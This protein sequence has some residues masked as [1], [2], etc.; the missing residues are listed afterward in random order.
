MWSN[1]GAVKETTYRSSGPM[2]VVR[3]GKLHHSTAPWM[4]MMPTQLCEL[5]GHDRATSGWVWCE[6]CQYDHCGQ[7]GRCCSE[8]V[9]SEES[10]QSCELAGLLD[11]PSAAA[12]PEDDGMQHFEPV[13]R[14]QGRVHFFPRNRRHGRKTGRCTSQ[15]LGH[16]P[17]SFFLLRQNATRLEE[18]RK[19]VFVI[20]P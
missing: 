1:D 4:P 10:S 11:D 14:L 3:M 17:T 5:C 6:K 15:H 9:E 13:T 16:G 20:S 2:Q 7:C 12:A 8:D 18:V 19:D